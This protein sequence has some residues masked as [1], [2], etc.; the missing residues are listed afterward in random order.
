MILPLISSTVVQTKDTCSEMGLF[1]LGRIWATFS[2]PEEAKMVSVVNSL[3][4]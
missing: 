2:L 1:S 4:N 3:S